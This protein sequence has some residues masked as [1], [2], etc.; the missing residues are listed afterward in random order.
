MAAVWERVGW[1]E[2][3]TPQS[4]TPGEGAETH[5]MR[6]LVIDIAWQSVLCGLYR[7]MFCAEQFGNYFLQIM[8]H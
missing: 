4:A 3:S 2:L 7:G 5:T 8:A 6:T 1:H